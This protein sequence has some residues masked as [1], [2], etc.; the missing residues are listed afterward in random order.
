M[1]QADYNVKADDISILTTEIETSDLQDNIYF[2]YPR[3]EIP[4]QNYI[5]VGDESIIG[6]GTTV[7]FTAGDPELFVNEEEAVG[8]FKFIPGTPSYVGT[9][10]YGNEVVL[11]KLFV[12]SNAK[13]GETSFSTETIDISKSVIANSRLVAYIDEGEAVDILFEDN[14]NTTYSLDV[15]K[16][17][18]F[19]EEQFNPNFIPES[20]F[21]L[22][23]DGSILSH[24][25]DNGTFPIFI[26]TESG[27]LFVG[28]LETNP[29]NA[30][31]SYLSATVE[32]STT[33]QFNVNQDPVPVVMGSEDNTVLIFSPTT[34]EVNPV[35]LVAEQ[36]EPYSFDPYFNPTNAIHSVLTYLID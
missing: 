30:I 26:A 5:V 13:V 4:E 19:P 21:I 1:G 7:P 24:P 18:N 29:D 6:A 36:T 27:N 17:F 16:E 23:E 14:L 2:N 20:D 10:N 8:G 33:E 22:A 32:Y 35:Y 34:D 9:P 28:Y 15:N 11:S 25:A 31:N 12:G 3:V